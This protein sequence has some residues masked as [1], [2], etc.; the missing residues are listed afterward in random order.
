ES[1]VNKEEKPQEEKKEEKPQEVVKPKQ[2]V[3]VLEKSGKLS[4]VQLSGNEAFVLEITTKG[5]SYVQVKNNQGKNYFADM[6][7]AG[8]TQKF[9]LSAENEVILNIGLSE[10]VEMKINGEV[11]AFP[12]SVNDYAHQIITV[13][14]LRS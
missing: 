10:N 6:M 1:P 2:E 13:K 5:Q 14:N 12:Q 8:N 11:I 7:N 9:D 3:K 4:T